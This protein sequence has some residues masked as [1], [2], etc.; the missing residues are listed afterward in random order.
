MQ[1]P[2]FYIDPS[3][4]LTYS[5]IGK[6]LHTET[7]DLLAILHPTSGAALVAPPYADLATR[8]AVCEKPSAGINFRS[9]ASTWRHY[10]TANAYELVGR[11]R[12]GEPLVIYRPLYPCDYALFA[13]PE[14]MFFETLADGKLRFQPFS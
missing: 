4:G 5:L 3:T 12:S 1:A 10:K 7:L 6:A 13:R 14:A 2:V 9:A 11:I 8:F